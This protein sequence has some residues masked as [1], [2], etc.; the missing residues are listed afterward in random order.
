MWCLCFTFSIGFLYFSFYG[1]YCDDTCTF[2]WYNDL[3]AFIT[4]TSFGLA[5]WLFAIE[6]RASAASIEQKLE[7]K[8]DICIRFYIKL[9]WYV[10]YAYIGLMGVGYGTISFYGRDNIPLFMASMWYGNSF[11]LGIFLA[12]TCAS[13]YVLGGALVGMKQLIR[14][15]KSVK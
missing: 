15:R 12:I 9:F 14:V 7:N 6:F 2:T 13:T 8:S 11:T 1:Y 5:Y 4:Y 3:V 10:S